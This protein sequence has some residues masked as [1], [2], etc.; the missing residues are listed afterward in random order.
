MIVLDP[1]HGGQDPGAIG[2]GN[3]YEKDLTL[4]M[5]REMRQLLEST[6]RYKVI[7]T[8]DDDS[9]VRLR[10]RVAEARHAGAE[11]FVSLH[12]DSIANPQVR[13]MSI[14]TLSDKASDREAE[15]LAAKEN[16]ADAI[17]G[18]DLSHE[19]DEVA[20]IL[21][22]LAQ[23]DTRNH[24]RRFARLVL[25]ESGREIKLLPQPD[26]SAG[27]AVLTAADVPSV[28]IEMGY[29]SSAQ[30]VAMLS[31]PRQRLKL[32]QALVR[33]IDGFFARGGA[34]RRL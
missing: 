9:F 19:N 28:L 29:L 11:L 23:R 4:A 15:M 34:G 2:T 12:A 17:G 6:G 25:H 31:Q 13:G 5:A 27:F 32:A 18:I 3:V 33:A 20:S 24:S 16:R 8:R 21:I 10:D 22:D 1:G 14:Y 26:R 30:D 7:L